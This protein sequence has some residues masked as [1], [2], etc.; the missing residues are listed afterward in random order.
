MVIVGT[1]GADSVK[2]GVLPSG[3]KYTWYKRRYV[4]K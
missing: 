1:F 2:D 3:E 4:K